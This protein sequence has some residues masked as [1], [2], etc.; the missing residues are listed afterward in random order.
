MSAG[1]ALP[2]AA[3]ERVLGRSG[4]LIYGCPHQQWEAQRVMQQFT[5]LADARI[6]EMLS[7]QQL[8]LPLSELHEAAARNSRSSSSN[9]SSVHSSSGGDSNGNGDEEQGSVLY[10]LV[11]FRKH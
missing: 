4:F 3:M 7:M 6:G 8:E 11:L 9:T 1:S 10:T 5:S 2:L